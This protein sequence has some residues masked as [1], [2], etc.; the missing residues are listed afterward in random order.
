M[1]DID[2]QDEY[3]LFKLF[4]RLIVKNSPFW[5]CICMQRFFDTLYS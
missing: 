3:E 5:D 4:G 2:E 1:V